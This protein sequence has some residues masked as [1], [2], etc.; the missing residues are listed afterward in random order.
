MRIFNTLLALALIAIGA[1]AYQASVEGGGDPSITAPIPAYVGAGI[2]FG[3]LVSLLLRKT[4]LALAFLA[5]LL[6]A[7]LGIGR[8]LPAHLDASLD[9]ADGYVKLLIAM[10]CVCTLQVLVAVI[11][12]LFRK[13]PEVRRKRRD[14][15]P[16]T[17]A[18]DEAPAIPETSR[19]A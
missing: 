7:G 11:R 16:A 3:V 9:P 18:R 19:P 8:L 15:R 17:P 6:G 4:G 1:M 5:A 14:G 12:F 2:L 13:R 10:I